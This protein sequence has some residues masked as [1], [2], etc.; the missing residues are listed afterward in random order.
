MEGF[1]LALYWIFRVLLAGFFILAGVLKAL[2]PAVFQHEI[3]S[4]Q[5]V[6]Y[7]LAFIAAY[8]LPYIEIMLGLGVLFGIQ[9]KIGLRLMLVLLSTFVVALAWTWSQGIDIRC[10]CLGSIDF[11]DGQ[12]A[13]ILRDLILMVMALYLVRFSFLKEKE[14]K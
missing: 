4:Y 6:G 7:P 14:A 3:V 2:D 10:G 12:P 5:L 9:K 11:V 8:Y 1:K 13:A